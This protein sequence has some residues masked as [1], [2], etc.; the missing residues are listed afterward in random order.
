M[1]E[2]VLSPG[3][4]RP[5]LH[6]EAGFARRQPAPPADRGGARAVR[7]PPALG[8]AVHDAGRAR[9]IALPEAAGLSTV[10]AELRSGGKIPQP[11]PGYLYLRAALSERRTRTSARA[12]SRYVF[13]SGGARL[14]GV[15]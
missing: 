5:P 8:Q 3:Q 1:D 13:G 10:A 15:L 14:R 4:C 9:P 12:E 2:S 7:G 6:V 11:V